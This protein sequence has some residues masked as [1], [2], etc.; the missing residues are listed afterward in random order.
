MTRSRSLT[1]L[2]VITTLTLFTAQAP[3]QQRQPQPT[4]LGQNAALW[5]WQAFAHMA[6]LD[7]EQRKLLSAPPAAPAPGAEAA[8]LADAGKDALLYLHR[9]AAI[10]ACDWGLHPED[11]PY[12]LLPHLA[13]GRDLARL[14]CLRARGEFARGD[15]PAGV[16]DA[17]DTLVMARHLSADLTAIITYLVQLGVERISIEAVAPHLAG[18]DKAS[19]DRLD[20]RL[21]ALPPGGS[22]EAC[23]RVE[24][25]A[26]IDWAI[27]HLRQMKDQDPWKEKVLQ[28]MSSSPES[29]TDVDAIVA[30][31]GGTRQGV[32]KALE[33]LRP[34]YDELARLLPLPRDQFRARLADLEK[35]MEG[36]PIARAV[37]PSMQRVYDRD[38]AG[39]TRLTLLKAAIA[40]V[41]AGPEKARDFKDASGA[42]IEYQATPDGFEL[43]SKVV[44]EDQP[45][46]LKV[47]GKR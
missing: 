37:M 18:L 46:V 21:A 17:A 25:D 31:C 33:G 5:Y 43:R 20:Q 40:V 42:S 34:Y 26:F 39:R 41:R 22:L 19:L 36:N 7:D 8:A 2:M 10:P 1:V 32:L 35:R 38:A 12:L 9:G 44:D 29:P 24:R 4:P 45:V 11:G 30:A 3:A 23:M 15:G 13:K 6:R 28:P 47:G 14:A 27:S 16:D